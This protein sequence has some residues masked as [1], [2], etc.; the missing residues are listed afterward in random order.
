MSTGDAKKDTELSDA[1]KAQIDSLRQE[2]TALNMTQKQVGDLIGYSDATVNQIWAKKYEKPQRILELMTQALR[3]LKNRTN[4]VPTRQFKQA[5]DFLSAANERGHFGVLLGMSGLGK[6]HAC[7]FFAATNENVSYCRWLPSMNMR[8]ML[9]AIADSVMSAP[10]KGSLY[11]VQL[12]VMRSLRQRPRM[13]I[14]DEADLMPEKMGNLIRSIHDDGACTLV[15]AGMPVLQRTLTG[16]TKNT[17]Y[18]YSRVKMWRTLENPEKLDVAAWASH[19]GYNLSDDM[20][21]D[22]LQ[23]ISRHGEYRMLRN[24]FDSVKKVLPMY[25]THDQAVSAVY[26]QSLSK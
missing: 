19:Y 6:T 10:A 23:W 11:E 7:E 18:V 5:N 14:I 16:G 2:F 22:L 3:R 15:L 20:T 24:L 12:D 26:K 8:E 13:L 21:N 17:A 4:V 9:Y 1:V 25:E